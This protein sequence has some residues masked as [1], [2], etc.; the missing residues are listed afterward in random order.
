LGSF[1]E[2][3]DFRNVKF[4]GTFARGSESAAGK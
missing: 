2:T 1:D 4:T 3:A